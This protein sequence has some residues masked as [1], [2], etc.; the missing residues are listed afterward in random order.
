MYFST[1]RS[2]PA[3]CSAAK[4]PAELR[5]QLVL[6]THTASLQYCEKIVVRVLKRMMASLTGG[7]ASKNLPTATAVLIPLFSVE[8]GPFLLLGKC[9][10]HFFTCGEAS[11][12]MD[13]I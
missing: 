11:R 9:V 5:L 1:H 12:S 13:D 7:G 10:V 2:F 3:P 4:R 8:L 6:L